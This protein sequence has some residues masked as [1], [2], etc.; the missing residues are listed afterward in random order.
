MP[1]QN[2]S[3]RFI[4]VVFALAALASCTGSGGPAAGSSSELVLAPVAGADQA[5]VV[6]AE[7]AQPLRVRLTDSS[8]AALAGKLV[9]FR[10]LRTNLSPSP[11]K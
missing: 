9:T 4:L 11:S 10:V 6:G 2:R 3:S 7:L 8:G 5:G 1:F